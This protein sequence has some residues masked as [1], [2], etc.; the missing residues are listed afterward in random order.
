MMRGRK[1]KIY[2]WCSKGN[3]LEIFSYKYGER[4]NIRHSGETLVYNALFYI[5]KLIF[6]IFLVL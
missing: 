6:I 3:I 1:V 2:N 5:F 4:K